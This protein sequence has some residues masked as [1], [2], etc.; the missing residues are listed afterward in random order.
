[1]ELPPLIPGSI[2]NQIRASI[3]EEFPPQM[4]SSRVVEAVNPPFLRWRVAGERFR[5]IAT[6][7]LP[8][9]TAPE[10]WMCAGVPAGIAV[11]P[12]IAWRSLVLSAEFGGILRTRVPAGRKFQVTICA[13]YN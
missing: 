7:I 12:V 10:E 1:M 8:M 9:L 6:K 4:K 5:Q 13:Y 2:A 3:W 11:R